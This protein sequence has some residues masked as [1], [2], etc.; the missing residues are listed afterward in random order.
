MLTWPPDYPEWPDSMQRITSL[1]KIEIKAYHS[2][3]SCFYSVHVINSF[4]HKHLCGFNL[5]IDNPTDFDLS[6]RHSVPCSL[7][8]WS[9][10]H[11]LHIPFFNCCVFL[12]TT[13]DYLEPLRKLLAN[14]DLG[15][16]IFSKSRLSQ[17]EYG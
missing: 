14:S 8:L 12:Q 17:K 2:V 5:L 16:D 13:T 9:S 10:N 11:L 6:F 4:V 15:E 3:E 1:D 7:Y